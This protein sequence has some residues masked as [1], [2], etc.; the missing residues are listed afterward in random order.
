MVR[1]SATSGPVDDFDQEASR[2]HDRATSGDGDRGAHGWSADAACRIRADVEIPEM[3]SRSLDVVV[4]RI[5]RQ[6]DTTVTTPRSPSAAA[7]LRARYSLGPAPGRRIA[8][9]GVGRRHR[10]RLDDLRV[11][12]RAHG[13]SQD[14]PAPPPHGWCAGCDKRACRHAGV[15]N[16]RR[17]SS[18]PGP[19]TVVRGT[20]G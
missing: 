11:F 17:T 8:P 3:A 12:D 15:E 19:S 20:N 1:P 4:A 5:S 10:P 14:D 16:S 18:R 13:R 2:Q 9:R 6:G 7:H